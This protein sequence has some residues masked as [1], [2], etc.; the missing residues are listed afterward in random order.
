M[1]VPRRDGDRNMAAT[2]ADFRVC[3]AVQFGGRSMP[4]TLSG[5]RIL[6]VLCTALAGCEMV[7]GEEETVPVCSESYTAKTFDHH[8]IGFY[9]SYKHG[10]LPVSEIRW[11][12]LTRIIYA[13][14]IP[15]SDGTLDVSGLTQ[16]GPLRMTAHAHGVEVYVSI[17]GGGSSGGFPLLARSA[18]ARGTFVQSVSRLVEEHCLDGVDI[19]WETWTKDAGNRPLAS[20][21]NDF[22]LLLEELN[23]GVG[24]AAISL[25]VYP[26]HWFGQHYPEVHHL[27]DYVQVMA[28]DFSGPWS[29]PGPHSSFQQAVGSGAG[30]SSTGLAYWAG[31]RRWPKTK[32]LLG[33]P[34]Y[35]RNFDDRD[36]FGIAY[37]D[38]VALD[39]DAPG[40]DRI[41]NIY[42]NGLQTITDKAQYVVDNRFP[43]VMIWELAQDVREPTLSLLGA[44][45]TIANP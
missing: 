32:L 25:D 10:V 26:S 34:F 7:T 37:R 38:I 44:I 21:M 12:H 39:A 16:T 18:D 8:V 17:G 27:V 5:W 28:Y 36:G 15:R 24:D 43:G 29:A 23:A 19:D 45:D 41:G 9:P 4:P 33:L 40:Q 1:Q 20:E 3:A 35:G 30:A 31:Y 2:A 6:V 14:A 11:D 22:R 42:Y 13:F